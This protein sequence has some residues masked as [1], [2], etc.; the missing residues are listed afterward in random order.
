M[1]DNIDSK[2]FSKSQLADCHNE[3]AWK[4]L[5]FEM[6]GHEDLGQAKFEMPIKF[7]DGCQV[8]KIKKNK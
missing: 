2:V 4:R 1:K 6:E 7:P 5:V 3:K 8:R